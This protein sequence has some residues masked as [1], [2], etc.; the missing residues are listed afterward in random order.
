MDSVRRHFLG[1]PLL[2]RR[3]IF[4]TF[5]SHFIVGAI[6][7]RS[8]ERN[9]GL[10]S[11]MRRTDG[12]AETCRSFWSLIC[13]PVLASEATRGQFPSASSCE[14]K[15]DRQEK[16]LHRSL[17]LQRSPGVHYPDDIT[18]AHAALFGVLLLIELLNDVESFKTNSVFCVWWLNDMDFHHCGLSR[19]GCVCVCMCVWWEHT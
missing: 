15:T 12:R 7:T 8:S 1:K 3:V 5:V 9:K 11:L 14:G 18:H 6:I 4:S 13:S 17:Y 16:Q 2:K 10:L 19:R